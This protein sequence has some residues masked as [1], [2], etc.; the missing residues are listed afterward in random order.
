MKR[1]VARLV[2]ECEKKQE[3]VDSLQV[4]RMYEGKYRAGYEENNGY[5]IAKRP[6]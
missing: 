6:I 2:N 1:E 3:K 5:R 4:N